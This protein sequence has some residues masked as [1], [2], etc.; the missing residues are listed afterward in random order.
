MRLRSYVFVALAAFGGTL[1]IGFST[2]ALAD[3][4]G[5]R[6]DCHEDYLECRAD[7][8]TYAYCL[9]QKQAC[10]ELCPPPG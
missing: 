7:G 10:V 8:N 1:G 3:G 9:A 6:G 4:D 2:A 5:C